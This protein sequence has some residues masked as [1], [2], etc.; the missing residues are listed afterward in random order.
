MSCPL[1]G[2][3]CR[4]APEVAPP[5]E[6]SLPEGRI[7]VQPKLE[8]AGKAERDVFPSATLIDPEAYDVSE[9]QFDVSLEAVVEERPRFIVEEA[10][11]LVVEEIASLNEPAPVSELEAATMAEISSPAENQDPEL[12]RNEVTARLN[13]YRSRRRTPEPRYPS[14]QLKFEATEPVWR[15]PVSE[16][17]T[18][19]PVSRHAVAF[20]NSQ[21]LAVSGAAAAAAPAPV[22][23]PVA[24]PAGKLLE[25]P[26]STLGPPTRLDELAGPVFDQPRIM[27]VPEVAPPPP[28]LGGI[29]MGPTE[30][31]EEEKR[32][33]FE[34]P[35][36]A[37]RLWRRLLA[38]AVDGIFVAAAVTL[39]GYAFFR[40]NGELLPL[41]ETALVGM[42]V[43]AFFWGGYQYLLLVY[44]GTTPG[45]A[46]AKLEPCR[47]DGVRALRGRRR[48][49]VLASF[50]SLASLGL[51]YF[52]CFLDED[53]LC[54]HD[55][56]TRTNLA[57]KLPRAR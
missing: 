7:S 30:G 36:Q 19:P 10:R 44:S 31:P 50:L 4:C 18:Q 33:G 46:L 12:W 35:L 11:E 1:C 32:P 27:E 22:P 43:A 17:S 41:R 56:I 21:P 20:Q 39:F 38:G 49:R 40:I 5:P 25:F 23:E 14:L 47:F 9:Q 6:S 15:S 26:R 3:I 45:L 28:A 57:P 8:P 52:W 34:I 48:W 24:E 37:A 54:W 2:E 55:R 42:A 29:L 13:Q 53:E 51:G 16:A